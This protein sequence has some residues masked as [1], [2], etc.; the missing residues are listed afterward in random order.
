VSRAIL[1]FVPADLDALSKKG[2]LSMVNE[3]EEFGYFTK[4][5]TIHP[6]TKKTQIY[7]AS[8]SHLIYEIGFDKYRVPKSL[9]FIFYPYHFLRIIC[10]AII[11]IKKNKVDVIRGN[12]PAWMGL[13]AYI[14]SFIT[15]VPYVVSIHSDI[16]K[17][18]Q[19][20]PKIRLTNITKIRSINNFFLRLIFLNAAYVLP[21]RKSLEKIPL[22]HGISIDKIKV[23]P[24]GIDLQLIENVSQNKSLLSE[25]DFD[26]KKLLSFVGRLDKENYV[27]DLLNIINNLNSNRSQDD[28]LLVIFGDGKERLHLENLVKSSLTL[29]KFVKFYGFKSREESIALRI[30]SSVNIC[31]MG[32]YSLL[33]ACA[34]GRPVV[35]YD[36]EWHA[37]LIENGI[38]GFL[39]KEHDIRGVAKKINYLL[40]NPEIS[41]KIGFNGKE[42]VKRNHNILETSKIKTTNFDALIKDY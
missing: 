1:Y 20:D 38:S 32:G 7:R 21:I 42:F 26:N 6:F 12:D 17:R 25:F 22:K 35:S 8:T 10:V 31:L 37:E 4:V 41:S 40:D 28:F 30:K 36:V 39:L 19:L 9:L 23:I 2:V 13:L 14:L 24:H 16:E 15:R 27:Y 34:S 29:N 11:L 5:I 3:R 33:E 18:N